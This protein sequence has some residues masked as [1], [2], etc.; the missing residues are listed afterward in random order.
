MT[1]IDDWQGKGLGTLLV[2]VVSA[3]ARA[4]GITTFSALMLARNEEMMDLLKRLDTVRIIDQELGT[5]EIE[6]PIPDG[7]IGAGAEAAAADRRPPRRGGAARGSRGALA[8][9]GV[10]GP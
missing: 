4:E 9:G 8:P 7:R 10:S 5:V 6:V 3:R 2:E 1:V